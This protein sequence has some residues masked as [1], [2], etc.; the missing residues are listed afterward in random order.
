MNH[1]ILR[2]T[3]ATLELAVYSA[4]SLIDLDADPTVIVTDGNGTIVTSGAVTKPGPP[5][6]VGVYRSVL[7]AQANLSLLTA[8]WT[9]QLAGQP[10]TLSQSYE[11]VG[12]LLFTEAEGRSEP[13][14]GQ[15]QALADETKYSDARIAHWRSV[16]GDIFE[17]R[18]GRGVTR[19]YCR[20]RFNGFVGLP[21]DLS[22]G[23]PVLANGNPLSRPGR[24]WDISTIISA[25]IDG[26]AQTVSDLEI[27][28]YKL[29]HTTESW[30]W[31]TAATPLNITIEYEYGPDPVEAETHQRALDL[32]LANAAP[33]GYP[34]TATSLSNED[35]TFRISNFPVAVEEFLKRRNHRTGL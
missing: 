9:G 25:T 32:L 10:L 8:V 12:N 24:S 18:M 3:P 28:G 33:S 1:H 30:A 16:I 11:I 27:V 13:I 4:G 20:T 5:D 21:L 26:V 6:D 22:G 23:Y 19:R 35:G 17:T 7:P 34:S 31:S 29:Y 14:V 15:Q 2:N